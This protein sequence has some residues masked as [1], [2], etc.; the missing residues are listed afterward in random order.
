MIKKTKKPIEYFEDESFKQDAIDTFLGLPVIP[1]YILT[2]CDYK[3]EVSF[4]ERSRSNKTITTS[5][6]H[7]SIG[8]SNIECLLNLK[9]LLVNRENEK[10]DIV[11]GKLYYNIGRFA[12]TGISYASASALKHWGLAVPYDTKT[13]A[14]NSKG[15]WSL[16]TLGLDFLEGRKI[17]PK[18]Y[19]KFKD[20]EILGYREPFVN[21][22]QLKKFD[23]SEYRETVT[24]VVC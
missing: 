8:K 15:M 17:I 22:Y 12:P 5:L 18:W 21:V 14:E 9:N 19:F 11:D 1:E 10:P 24:G 4:V 20:G 6:I 3:D 7:K 13:A 16:T 23:E 2:K